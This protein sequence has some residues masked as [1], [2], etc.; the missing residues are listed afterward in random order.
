MDDGGN[1]RNLDKLD[2]QGAAHR[3]AAV[4][5]INR[6][7]WI[8]DHHVDMPATPPPPDI[9]PATLDDARRNIA[10]KRIPKTITML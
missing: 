6:C 4:P 7:E 8:E 9:T 5:P 10:R 3:Q 2:G 1:I